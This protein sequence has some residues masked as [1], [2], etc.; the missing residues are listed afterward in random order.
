MSDTSVKVVKY[1]TWYV[2]CENIKHSFCVEKSP[3]TPGELEANE[4]KKYLGSLGTQA[5]W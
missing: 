5:F 1:F 2:F 4:A 3:T